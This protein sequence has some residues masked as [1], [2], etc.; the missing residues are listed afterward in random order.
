ML[1]F[2]SGNF[3]LRF[4]Y[5]F[6]VKCQFIK[7]MLEFFITVFMTYKINHIVFCYRAYHFKLN[8]FFDRNSYYI[9]L[10]HKLYISFVLIYY[11]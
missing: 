6:F 1:F 11:N 4:C 9:I 3:L 5:C 10:I 8:H 7:L 2:K